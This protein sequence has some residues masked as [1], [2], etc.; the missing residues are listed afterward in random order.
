MLPS[1]VEVGVFLMCVLC[2]VAGG[3]LSGLAALNSVAFVMHVVFCTMIV[4]CVA[5]V[6]PIM[7]VG[8]FGGLVTSA[9]LGT[10]L[11]RG[12]CG[13]EECRRAHLD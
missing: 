12:L 7:K 10:M 3:W 6:D 2:V 4:V 1:F 9:E 8:A 11:A 13:Y 5:C